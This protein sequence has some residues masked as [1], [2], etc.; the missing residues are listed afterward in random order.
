MQI[1]ITNDKFNTII[2][3]MEEV[4]SVHAISVSPK[5]VLNHIANR[6][7]SPYSSANN[8]YKLK[9]RYTQKEIQKEFERFTVDAGRWC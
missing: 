5:L 3:N 8:E 4:L 2:T 6:L 9:G 7:G 1:Q